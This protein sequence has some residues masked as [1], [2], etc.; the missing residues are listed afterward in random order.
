MMRW[1]YLSSEAGRRDVRIPLEIHLAAPPFGRKSNYLQGL[2]RRGEDAGRSLPSSPRH[3]PCCQHGAFAEQLVVV[4]AAV[5]RIVRAAAVEDVVALE[6]ANDIGFVVSLPVMPLMT[7][8]SPLQLPIA[9]GTAVFFR[10]GGSPTLPQV[11][12]TIRI[13]ET[14]RRGRR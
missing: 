8:M 12:A 1:G 5:E 6:A 4:L 3:C 10:A 7:A 14:P 9:A 11:A 13:R 2:V